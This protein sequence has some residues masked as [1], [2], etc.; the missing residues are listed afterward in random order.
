M[1]KTLILKNVSHTPHLD[2]PTFKC[3]STHV[4]GHV[5]HTYTHIHILCSGDPSVIAINEVRVLTEVVQLPSRV[6]SLQ[7][8]GLQHTR[9]PCPSPSPRV[10]PSPCSLHRGWHPAISSSD[11]LFSFCRQSFP[12]SGTFPVSCLF[13]SDDQNTGASA[14]HQ[15]FQ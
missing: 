3:M 4:C 8:H 12:A 10:C 2:F 1:N 14:S 7:S 6:Y 15:S 13:E 5:Q 9:P 11:T